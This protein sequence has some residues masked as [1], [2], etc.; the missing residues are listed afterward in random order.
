MFGGGI[1]TCHNR[2]CVP[3]ARDTFESP[4]VQYHGTPPPA[5]WCGRALFFARATICLWVWGAIVCGRC[6]SVG[7]F[8]PVRFFFFRPNLAGA[9]PPHPSPPL[10]PPSLGPTACIPCPVSPSG[11][12]AKDA[13]ADLTSLHL[14]PMGSLAWA[15]ATDPAP[16]SVGFFVGLLVCC[17]P[18]RSHSQC[19]LDQGLPHPVRRHQRPPR[20]PPPPRPIPSQDPPRRLPPTRPACPCHP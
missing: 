13:A 5:Q 16:T 10:P 17:C 1:V 18:A 9:L 12:R 19:A 11:G 20:R 8:F 15:V 3:A 7:F 6:T 2:L 14:P 4:L